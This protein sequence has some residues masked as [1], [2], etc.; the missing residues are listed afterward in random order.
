MEVVYLILLL[1]TATLAQQNKSIGKK[2]HVLKK[3][4]NLF[5]A[6][7]LSFF[8]MAVLRLWHNGWG[9][10]RWLGLN[11]Y[12]PPWKMPSARKWR[13]H[14]W[15]SAQVSWA[16]SEQYRFVQ[17]GFLLHW[18]LLFQKY[19]PWRYQ[20]QAD[21]W[22]FSNGS[23]DTTKQSFIMPSVQVQPAYQYRRMLP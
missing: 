13:Y 14:H 9:N 19:V 15:W 7:L 22:M 2:K 6:D 1:A 8:R 11:I 16:E 10:D 18:W 3:L 12:E 4:A 20:S 17:I 21:F 5:F 23:I